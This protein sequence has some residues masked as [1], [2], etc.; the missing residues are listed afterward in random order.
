VTAIIPLFLEDPFSGLKRPNRSVPTQYVVV[1]LADGSGLSCHNT[2][3]E[4]INM[5]AQQEKPG[6]YFIETWPGYGLQGVEYV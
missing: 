1:D 3:N 2:R 4:A 5:I 6:R